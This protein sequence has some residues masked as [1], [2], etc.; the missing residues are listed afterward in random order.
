MRIL[1]TAQ[2]NEVVNT[3]KDL[4]VDAFEL[5]NEAGNRSW[6]LVEPRSM[7]RMAVREGFDKKASK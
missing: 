3:R 6:P 2:A 4:A 1:P 7:R 5:G